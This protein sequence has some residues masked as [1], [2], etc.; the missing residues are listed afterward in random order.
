MR[1]STIARSYAGALFALGE[2]HGQTDE[3]GRA[4]E[5]LAALMESEPRLRRFLATPKVE[6]AAKKGVLEVALEGRV[7]PLFLSFLKV[8]VDKRRQRLLEEIDREFRAI[9]DEHLGR[10]HAQVT[11]AREPDERTEREIATHLTQVL[12]KT[13]IPHLRVDPQILGGIIV[14]YGDRLLDG[15]LRRRLVSLR[16]RLLEAELPHSRS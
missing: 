2:R 4:L 5:T 6:P 1:E 7:P 11:L 14:R 10:V 15:S 12:G 3:F 16:R 13:V 9:L 8:V